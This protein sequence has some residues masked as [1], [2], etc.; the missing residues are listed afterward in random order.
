LRQ[1]LTAMRR[2]WDQ[3]SI[4]PR[5]VDFQ[6][7]LRASSAMAPAPWRRQGVAAGVVRS[8]GVFGVAEGIVLEPGHNPDE[9][10]CHLT[11]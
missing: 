2:L 6:L 1:M 11:G 7:K 3:F 4:G 8:P 9:L 5:G 10:V